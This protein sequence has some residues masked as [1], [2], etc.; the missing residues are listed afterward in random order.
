MDEHGWAMALYDGTK[1]DEV[2]Q[3]ARSIQP[4]ALFV[5][6]ASLNESKYNHESGMTTNTF[7]L[8]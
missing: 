5:P 4:G 3:S 1:R 6:L 8:V 7:L 2:L